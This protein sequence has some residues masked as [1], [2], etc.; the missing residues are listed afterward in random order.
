MAARRFAATEQTTYR[1]LQATMRKLGA[2]SLRVAARDMLN[3]KDTAAEIVFDRGGKRSVRDARAVVMST[4]SE[5][6]FA[7]TVVDIA[8]RGQWTVYRTYRSTRSPAGF[9]DLVLVRSG[10]LIFAELKREGKAPTPAQQA[11]LAQLREVRERCYPSV[12]VFVWRPT[13]IDEIRRI[14]Q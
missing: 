4:V 7:Q 6:T 10:R 5:K 8:T 11:W 9:P 1:D 12:L 13:D 3:A 14:L 2:A